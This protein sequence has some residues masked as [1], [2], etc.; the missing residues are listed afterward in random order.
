MPTNNRISM[1]KEELIFYMDAT[2][3]QRKGNLKYKKSNISEIIKTRNRFSV[4]EIEE[5]L[6]LSE[7]Y[8]VPR[9][10]LTV[11]KRRS[12]KNKIKKCLNRKKEIRDTQL[13]RSFKTTNAF[14]VLEKFTEDENEELITNTT[15]ACQVLKKKKKC[16]KCGYKTNCHLLS[17]CKSKG[18]TCFACSKKNHFPQSKNCKVKKKIEDEKIINKSVSDCVSLRHFLRTAC[19]KLTTNVIPYAELAKKNNREKRKPKYQQV[20]KFKFDVCMV[21]LIQDRLN[22]LEELKQTSENF[23][24]STYCTRFFLLSYFFFNMQHIIVKC[25]NDFPNIIWKTMLSQMSTRL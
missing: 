23:R 2:E 8:I 6:I 17:S 5:V 22:V 14:S 19:F 12:C 4:L 16:S 20:S 10:K 3:V 21:N 1:S 25:Y 11:N 15:E 9:S 7:E 24:D 18:K 13:L